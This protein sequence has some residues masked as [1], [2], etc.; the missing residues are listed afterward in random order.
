MNSNNAGKM[1]QIA[2]AV[3]RQIA[4]VTMQK[5]NI[6]NSLPHFYPF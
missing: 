4:S 1:R 3:M 2:S 5:K 6:D